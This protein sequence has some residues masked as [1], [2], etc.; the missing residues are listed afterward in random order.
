MHR[1]VFSDNS[2]LRRTQFMKD[3]WVLFKRE[4]LIGH[5]LEAN[6]N[7]YPAIQPFYYQ[8]RYVHNHILQVLADQGLLGGIP[9]LAFLESVLWLL[10]KRLRAEQDALAA[11]LLAR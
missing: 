11:V 10:V 8:S 3:T 5:G 9:F 4:P 2:F 1:G 7:L 6:D